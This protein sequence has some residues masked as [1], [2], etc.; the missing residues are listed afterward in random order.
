MRPLKITQEQ[1]DLMIE[2][3]S[4]YLKSVSL[5][6]GRISFEDIV[7]DIKNEQKV[8]VLFTSKAWLK[9]RDLVDR[10]ASEVGWYGF[11]DKVSAT[12]YKVTDICVYPQ[13]V[14]GATVDQGNEQW[15]ADMPIEQI[16]RRHFHGHSHVNMGVT[17]SVT[18]IK[19]RDD[20]IAMTRSN[21]FYFFMIV[22]KSC[23]WSA[24]LFDLAGNAVYNTD[25]ILID[26]DLGD[27]ELLSDFI[28]SAKKQ[29]TVRTA[30]NYK[31]MMNERNGKK[32]E[33]VTMP[34]FPA[35][36][37][38]PWLPKPKPSKPKS[39]KPKIG[40]KAAKKNGYSFDELDED[41]L[42]ELAA[43]YGDYYDDLLGYVSDAPPQFLM[44]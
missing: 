5:T 16:K 22:N 29:I 35:P 40:K 28:E 39:S 8:R 19:D 21:S 4:K 11:I 24:Q 37:S 30:D 44:R 2:K 20:K 42:E 9:M 3:F 26:V 41:A 15:D 23:A 7:A 33:Q 18:D 27:G 6:T 25:D 36:A 1:H 17:P 43:S 12:E 31:A 38:S 32:E 13:L 14:A 10:Y 34:V